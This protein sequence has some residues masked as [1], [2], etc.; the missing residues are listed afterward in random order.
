MK[1][2]PIL[3][4][5]FERK[6]GTTFRNGKYRLQSQARKHIARQMLILLVIKNY[7]KNHRLRVIFILLIFFSSSTELS[8]ALRRYGLVNL[9]RLL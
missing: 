9:F 2:L 6:L 7:D 4:K 1:T 8:A 3:K 5:Q